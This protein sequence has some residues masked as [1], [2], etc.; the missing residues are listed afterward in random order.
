MSSR[1]VRVF[2]GAGVGLL[3][4]GAAMA[5]PDRVGTLALLLALVL[6]A[7][8]DIRTRRIPNWLTAGI[9]AFA[10]AQAVPDAVAAAAA[11]GAIGT[12]SGLA[13]AIV[14][15][16][17]FG[18]GD[19]K[20]MGA[21]GAV[22]GLPML[23]AFLFTMALLGGVHALLVLMTAGGSDIRR[24]TMPYGPAIAAACALVVLL[25]R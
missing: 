12:A 4:G 1:R 8:I 22:V 23:L 21:V 15:R 19:V 3:V 6:A 7:A 20:L 17:G 16:G 13:I 5:L 2:G 24:R 11:A 18:M 25:G 10:L 14:A 9:A